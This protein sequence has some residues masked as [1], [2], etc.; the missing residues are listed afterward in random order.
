[1][2]N[3]LTRR[4]AKT[5]AAFEAGSRPTQTELARRYG[6][7]QP[8]ISMRLQSARAK[9]YGGRFAAIPARVV[10][11]PVSISDLRFQI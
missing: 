10:M 2:W 5:L 6:V 3:R 11:R 1:M 8:A 4:E 7:G 9:K